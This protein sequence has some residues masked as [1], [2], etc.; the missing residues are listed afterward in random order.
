NKDGSVSTERSMTV[1]F[2]DDKG[3]DFFVNIPTIQ[4]GVQLT[5]SNAVKAAKKAGIRKYARFSTKD[6]AV[7]AAK[8]RSNSIGKAIKKKK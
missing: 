6:S 8:K 7:T 4:N 2:T 1:G 3:K 5:G